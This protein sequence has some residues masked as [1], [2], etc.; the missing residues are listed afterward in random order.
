ML[1]K[2]ITAVLLTLFSSLAYA[3]TSEAGG[4]V[5]GF[6]HPIYGFDHLVAM[7]AVGILGAILGGRAVWQLPVYFPLAMAIGG[8]I[9]IKGIGLP[10]TEIFIALSAVVLGVLIITYRKINLILASIIVGFFALFHG[11]AHGTELPTAVSPVTYSIGFVLGTGL[12]HL[13]GIL[14]S[15]IEHKSFGK[16]VLKICGGF[17]ALTGVYFLFA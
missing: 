3:H 16:N 9:G 17:V 13:A 10:Y 11:H 4:F 14:I 2:F 12:L 15:F 6:L 8:V 7:V 5:S 1:L